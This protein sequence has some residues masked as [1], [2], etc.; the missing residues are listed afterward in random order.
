M[1]ATET[2]IELVVDCQPV[3]HE[4]AHKFMRRWFLVNEQACF[5]R[6][7][8]QAALAAVQVSV[9]HG[10]LVLRAPGMLRLDIPMDVIEDDDSVCRQV[11]VGAQTVEV[12]DEG[13]LAAVWFGNVTGQACRLVK[14]H[15]D[16][17]IPAFD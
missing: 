4:D 11:T 15:P 9:T 2:P 8:H 16:A 10:N 6:S 5:D 13:D 3:T 1:D 7:A 17:A 12:V 14:V